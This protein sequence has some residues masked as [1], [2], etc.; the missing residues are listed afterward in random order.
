M[1]TKTL[2]FTRRNPKSKAVEKVGSLKMQT[3]DDGSCELDF[4]GDICS[5]DWERWSDED[6]CPQN[7]ADFLRGIDP[8]APLNIY[9]NSGGGDV[10][11]G[12]AIYNQLRRHEGPITVTVDG[13][14]ASIA[15]VIALAG[16]E[17]IMLSGA[18]L[19]IHKPWSWCMG[20]AAEM[21]RTAA[22]LDKIEETILDIYEKHAKEGVTRE[23]I[24]ELVDAETWM[25]GTEAAQIFNV[26]VEQGKA[27]AACWSEFFGQYKHPPEIADKI[28][29]EED[30]PPPE[31]NN[32]NNLEKEKLQ[33]KLKLLDVRLF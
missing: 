32:K 11:G 8:M 23:R 20:D 6:K 17:L 30:T 25:S 12:V 21:Q 13:L 14:A 1:T 27:A 18:Q 26:T 31:E 4:Y 15:S 9:I 28:P 33:I 10:F 22:L 3:L 19:M 2:D 24:R 16:D 5:A 29:P 7:I